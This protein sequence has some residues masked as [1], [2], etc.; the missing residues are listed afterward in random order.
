MFPMRYK[1]YVL[2]VLM[3]AAIITGSCKKA[4]ESVIENL[5][6]NLIT[7]NVWV[8]TKFNVGGSSITTDFSAYEFHFNKDNSVNAVKAGAPD[9]IGTWAGSEDSKSITANFPSAAYPI[10]KLTGVWIVINTD[11]SPKLVDSHRYE[12]TTELVMRLNAK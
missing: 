2:G 10:N 4:K 8:V 11:L 6:I 1:Q 9:V 5:M 7:E 3:I 12:G